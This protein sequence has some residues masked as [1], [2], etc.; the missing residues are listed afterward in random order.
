MQWNCFM[1]DLGLYHRDQQRQ[2]SAFASKGIITCKDINWPWLRHTPCGAIVINDKPIVSLC[3]QHTLLFSLFERILT[4]LGLVIDWLQ[5]QGTC[6]YC[7]ATVF[8]VRCILGDFTN[9]AVT[10]F[11]WLFLK[12]L[13]FISI[14][15]CFT[16]E[17]NNKLALGEPM[18]L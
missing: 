4:S 6:P 11:D 12:M 8:S 3:F 10:G 9:G 16:L 1:V 5:G 2:V 15:W 13:I 7:R 18:Y 14:H 17:F